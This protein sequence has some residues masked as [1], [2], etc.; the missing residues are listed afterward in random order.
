M[1]K[2]IFDPMKLN[3]GRIRQHLIMRQR[4]Y[5]VIQNFASP[6]RAEMGQAPVKL[7]KTSNIFNLK[8]ENQLLAS[9]TFYF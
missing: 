2:I 3:M 9:E 7:T 4:N 6:S 8:W 1:R 5:R